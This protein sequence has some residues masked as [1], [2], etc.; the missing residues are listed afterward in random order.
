MK[1][2]GI[3]SD[4]DGETLIDKVLMAGYQRAGIDEIKLVLSTLLFDSEDR[5]N[6][7]NHLVLQNNETIH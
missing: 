1:E 2:L 7:L 5:S 6:S 4:S 3:I